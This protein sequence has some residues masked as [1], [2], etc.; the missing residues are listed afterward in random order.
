MTFLLDVNV[1]VALAW[2]T[3]VHHGAADA[4][5]A[6]EGHSAWAT[7]PITENGFVRVSS[8]PRAIDGAVSPPS[9]TALL[10]E[11]RRLPGHVFWPADASISEL[12]GGDLAAVVGHRQV[13]RRLPPRARPA[14]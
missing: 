4:W 3:H 1:L 6:T 7:T 12:D 10:A 5:F 13:D 2:P 9:A 8:N 11:M 14:A